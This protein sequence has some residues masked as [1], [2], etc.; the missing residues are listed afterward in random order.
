MGNGERTVGQVAFPAAD[1]AHIHAHAPMEAFRGKHVFITG[2]SG[3][4]GRWLRFAL[5]R[6]S[7]SLPT[8]AP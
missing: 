7:R 2:A 4:F 1:L 8:S 3:W 6:F 5:K